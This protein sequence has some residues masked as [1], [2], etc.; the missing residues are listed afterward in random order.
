M[1]EKRRRQSKTA[2]T[3]PVSVPRPVRPLLETIGRLA[4]AQGVKAYAVGGCVR[5]WLLGVPTITDVDVTVEGDGIGFANH[6]AGV[7]HGSV[8]AHQ[9]FGT[10]TLQLPRLRID[11][12]TA[13]KE[14]YA[15]PA[16][17]PKVSA[18][19]LRDDLFRRDF[20][21]NA[22]AMTLEPD[23]FGTLIDP[24]KGL[25]DLKAKHLRILHANS[26][27]DDPSRIL[28]AVRFAA[29]YRFTLEPQTRWRL[30]QAVAAGM[31]ERLN[32]GR[33][34]KEFQRMGWLRA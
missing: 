20:T 25:V 13:R 15:E 10:A 30:R 18:G 32:R 27:V 23:R 3:R 5:D 28:R 21:V 7:L 8:E 14:T 31:L 33:L 26:F 4:H 19:R 16:A 2:T 11:V 1:S 17:Y 34:R 6:V 29:R 9:Q 24:F 22:M 12:V